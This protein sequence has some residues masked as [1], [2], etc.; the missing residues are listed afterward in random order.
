MC[1]V[2]WSAYVA[3][4]KKLIKALALVPLQPCTHDASLC[5]CAPPCSAHASEA[6]LPIFIHHSLSGNLDFESASSQRVSCFRK[7]EKSE[8]LHTDLRPPLMMQEHSQMHI[9]AW[10]QAVQPQE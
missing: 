3:S 8:V 4:N 5:T 9:F 10:R 2:S 6:A 7:Q 1:S